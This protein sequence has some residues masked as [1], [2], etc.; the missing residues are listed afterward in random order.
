MRPLAW[1]PDELGWRVPCS[2]LCSSEAGEGKHWNLGDALGLGR[3]SLSGC[4]SPCR[5]EGAAMQLR[6][7]SFRW[8]A[9][10][11]DLTPQVDIP[12]T[13]LRKDAWLAAR[14]QRGGEPGSR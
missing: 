2:R 8:V 1:M 13:V 9:P 7:L 14:M 11:Q 3:A 4:R 6:A 12:K 10:Q 5:E